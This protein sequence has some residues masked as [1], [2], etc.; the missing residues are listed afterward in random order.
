MHIHAQKF[1]IA[2]VCVFYALNGK[3]GLDQ[4]F[5]SAPRAV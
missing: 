3:G 4:W 2:L 1:N 5:I